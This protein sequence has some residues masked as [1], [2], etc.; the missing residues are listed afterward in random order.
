MLT[1]L[2]PSLLTLGLFFLDYYYYF[3]LVF[4]SFSFFCFVLDLKSMQC[5]IYHQEKR[6]EENDN[7]K[8]KKKF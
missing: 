4:C 3:W 1:K 2:L 7:R 5:V 8:K 6:F